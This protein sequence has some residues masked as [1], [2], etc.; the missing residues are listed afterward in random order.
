MLYIAA[1]NPTDAVTEGFLPAA[2]RFDLPVVVLTDQPDAHVAA[3]TDHPHPPKAVIACDVRQAR[4]LIDA[5][6]RHGPAAALL[7]NSD[8]LQVPTAQAASFLGLAGKDWRA[9]LR[10]KDKALTRRALADAGLDRVASAVLAPGEGPPA[11]LVYPAVIKP[12]EGVASEDA[13]LVADAG[14]LAARLGEIRRRRPDV[15]LIVEECLSGDLYTFDTLGDAAGLA[16]AGS[17]RT[18]LGP[19]PTFVEQRLDWA[20]ELDGGV[21]ETLLAT[22]RALGVGLG[23]CHTEF[24]LSDGRPRIIE[25]NY[26]LIGDRM[27]LVLAQLLDVPLFEY[28]IRLHLGEPVTALA[29]PD[30]ATVPRHAAVEYVCADRAGTLRSA[31]G[32]ID[33]EVGAVRLACSPL[34]TI[35]AT[36][37]W[38]GTNRDYLAAI[39]AIGPD[40]NAV[41]AA[42]AGFRAE[43]RWVIA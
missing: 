31:P 25:V 8:H 32:R 36:A 23:A 12:R 21:R 2:A 33:I 13:Y 35:G 26:R 40:Q 43:H 38:Y 10:C 5:V 16:V 14:D 18:T 6:Y 17:W 9:A 4:E 34:R 39:H 27:D 15:A 3:Y 11:G 1:L 7:S 24:V 22:L 30:P 42:I 28:L 37:P 41:D 29:L 20:P 19:P